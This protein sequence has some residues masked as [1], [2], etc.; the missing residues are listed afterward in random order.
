MLLKDERIVLLSFSVWVPSHWTLRSLRFDWTFWSLVIVRN[1]WRFP[2]VFID[3]SSSF[4]FECL[5][6]SGVL[7]YLWHFLTCNWFRSLGSCLLVQWHRVAQIP[8]FISLVQIIKIRERKFLFLS[9]HIS[10]HFE[11]LGIFHISLIFLLR[12]KVIIRA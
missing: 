12:N 4:L 1:T 9:F 5:V 8:N 6:Q 3:V 7:F 11:I 2:R 10:L